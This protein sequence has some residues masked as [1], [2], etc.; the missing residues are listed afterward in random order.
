MHW[1]QFN[2]AVV[3]QIACTSPSNHTLGLDGCTTP[4]DC[5]PP[6]KPRQY[7]WLP[8]YNL[9][10]HNTNCALP[11]KKTNCAPYS[12]VHCLISQIPEVPCND[13]HFLEATSWHR[14]EYTPLSSWASGRAFLYREAIRQI[15][16][17]IDP[18]SCSQVWQAPPRYQ[19][20]TSNT[21]QR[22]HPASRSKE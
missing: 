15:H 7:Y 12:L 3:L 16:L 11:K 2:W 4:P 18:T 14:A 6:P 19:C 21:A 9:P 22:K 5:G 10:G 13:H 17:A 20:K 1:S 8:R